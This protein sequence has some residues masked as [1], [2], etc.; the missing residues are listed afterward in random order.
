MR[1]PVVVA[2]EQSSSGSTRGE[3]RAEPAERTSSSL[4][5][6]RHGQLPK[7]PGAQLAMSAMQY[8]VSQPLLVEG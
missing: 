2:V 8:D 4:T 6:V 1:P 5:Q 7:V 3:L